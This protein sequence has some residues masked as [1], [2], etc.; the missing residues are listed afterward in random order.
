MSLRL[1][2]SSGTLPP[3][4]SAPPATTC[5]CSVSAQ[6]AVK[7]PR[8][9][10]ILLDCAIS[11]GTVLEPTSP[12]ATTALLLRNAQK[13]LP[14]AATLITSLSCLACSVREPPLVLTP[15]AAKVCS[16]PESQIAANRSEE[17]TSE[18]QSREN[19]VCRLLLEKKNNNQS[20]AGVAS[21]RTGS[22]F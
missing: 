17:H 6:T 14:E 13:A 12:Q 16:V 7:L 21:L 1:A 9:S 15:H 11:W 10:R 5:P 8:T 4:S 19:L 2:I 20:S 18:L 22:C 3:S